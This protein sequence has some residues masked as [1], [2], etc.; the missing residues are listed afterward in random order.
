MTIK[1]KSN[2]GGI[3]IGSLLIITGLIW[4]GVHVYGSLNQRFVTLTVD[5]AVQRDGLVHTDVGTFDNKNNPILGK[6]DS[7]DIASDLLNGEKY[8]CNVTGFDVPAV[9]WRPNLIN[10]QHWGGR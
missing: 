5:R 6:F 1:R 8:T 9:G 7:E 3:S 2:W 4:L 10:C